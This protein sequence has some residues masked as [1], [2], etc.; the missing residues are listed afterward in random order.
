MHE[1]EGGGSEGKY[2]K[3]ISDVEL[4]QSRGRNSSPVR[5]KN[6]Y[7]SMSSRPALRSYPASYPIGTGFSFPC[8]KVAGARG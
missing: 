5:A 2:E 1:G 4:G 6:F 7:I 8:G 3:K